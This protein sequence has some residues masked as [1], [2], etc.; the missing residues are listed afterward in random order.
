MFLLD[1]L[2]GTK[3]ASTQISSNESTNLITGNSEQ[4]KVVF[5]KSTLECVSSVIL[6]SVSKNVSL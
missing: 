5:I 4:H 3:L 2:Q 6:T 1:A